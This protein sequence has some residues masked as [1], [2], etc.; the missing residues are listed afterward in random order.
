MNKVSKTLPLIIFVL[1]SALLTKAQSSY[2]ILEGF[3]TDSVT[4]KPIAFA[5]VV[6]NLSDFKQ[7]GT[8][9]DED[10]HYQIKLIPPGK[11]EVLVSHRTYG[12]IVY[13]DFQIKSGQINR[14]N[15]SMN[16]K[17]ITYGVVKIS[18]EKMVDAEIGPIVVLG[19]AALGKI[20]LKKISDIVDVMTPGVI[21][22]SFKGQRNSAVVYYVDGVK[23]RGE[24]G[25]PSSSIQEIK[26]INGALPAEYGDVLGGVVVITTISGLY[27][28]N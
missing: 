5:S 6:I 23:V 24:P 28:G 13:E 27:S 1:L 17:S 2:G 22:G 7:L 3:I 10:G 25:V 18:A 4:Q 20:P 15:F 8:T 21:N 11:F 14:L 9:T 26:V 16:M 19:K 12:K